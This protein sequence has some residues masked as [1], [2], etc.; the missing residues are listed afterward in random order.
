MTTA[1]LTNA[2]ET[3]LHWTS[4][5]THITEFAFTWSAE[6]A[7]QNFDTLRR[8]QFDVKEA[9]GQQPFSALTI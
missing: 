4:P 7:Q 2:L 1:E 8:Y 5:T 3:A 6:A 9:I